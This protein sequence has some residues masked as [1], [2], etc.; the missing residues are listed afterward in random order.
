MFIPPLCRSWYS[1]TGPGRGEGVSEPL[2]GV[3]E[4]IGIGERGEGCWLST[5]IPKMEVCVCSQGGDG[6]NPV[7][8][9][10]L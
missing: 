4:V 2:K 9:E 7:T 10:V 3:D 1:D 8:E 6:S 5:S